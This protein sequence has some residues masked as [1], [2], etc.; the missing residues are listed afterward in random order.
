MPGSGRRGRFL[1]CVERRGAI[2][3]SPRALQHGFR[4]GVAQ[5]KPVLGL[6]RLVKMLDREVPV[7]GPILLH[8][9]FDPVHRR[10]P[11]GSP[12]APPVDQ[13]LRPLRIVAVAQPA[14]MPLADPQQLGRLYTAQPPASISL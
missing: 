2:A 1:R 9:K 8:D 7:P 11:P 14:E 12:P 10:P 6:Q 5:R 13:T 4:P 3:T